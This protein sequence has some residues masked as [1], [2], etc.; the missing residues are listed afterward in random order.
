VDEEGLKEFLVKEK[1]FSE[2][3]VEGGIKKIQ[4]SYKGGSQVRLESFFG[5]PVVTK[6]SNPKKEQTPSKSGK[7]IRK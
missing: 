2:Q 7:K 6:S 3:K 4:A 1:G 5:K